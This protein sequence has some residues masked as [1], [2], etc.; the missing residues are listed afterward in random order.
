MKSEEKL[1]LPTWKGA[2]DRESLETDATLMQRQGLIG[3]APPFDDVVAS[4]AA[5]FSGCGA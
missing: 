3:E 2:I 4:G 5:A 1:K